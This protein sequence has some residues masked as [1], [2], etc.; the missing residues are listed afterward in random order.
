MYLLM[1]FL[2]VQRTSYPDDIGVDNCIEGCCCG[3]NFMVLDAANGVII[4][5]NKERNKESKENWKLAMMI[6]LV[7]RPNVA[8]AQKCCLPQGWQIGLNRHI[9]ITLLLTVQRYNIHTLNMV[10]LQL[11]HYQTICMQLGVGNW[12]CRSTVLMLLRMRMRQ[13]C[14]HFD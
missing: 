3:F 9:E 1:V 6:W 7:Y 5:Y 13:P 11:R 2:L 12:Y 10:L 4:I 8:G 14:I